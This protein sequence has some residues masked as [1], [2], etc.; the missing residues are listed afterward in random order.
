M[1]KITSTTVIRPRRI[2]PTMRGNRMEKSF[3]QEKP[4]RVNWASCG[5]WDQGGVKRKDVGVQES[6]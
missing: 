1:Q 6:R 4:G 5:R 2:R 3:G